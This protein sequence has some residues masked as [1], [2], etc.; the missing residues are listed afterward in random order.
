MRERIEALSP[1][2]NLGHRGA[3]TSRAANPFPENSRS[4][5]RAAIDQGA[6]GVELDVEL[7]SDGALVAMHDDT[8]DRT[9]TCGGCVSTKTL[10]EIRACRLRRG[11]GRPTDER[12]PTLAESFAAI[13]DDAVVNVELKVFGPECRTETTGP[14]ALARAAVERVRELGVGHRTMFSSFDPAA[15]AAVREES[16][17]YAA[18][19]LDRA[20]SV[21]GAWPAAIELAHASDL[22]AIHP[23]FAIPAAGVR[24]ARAA[25]L[26]VNVWTINRRKHMKRA[27]D[28][29][30]TAIITDEPA[31]LVGV[32]EGRP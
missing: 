17:F 26:H 32:L 15:V 9:T 13:P 22:D 12:P 27:L 14:R 7:T 20:A 25:G 31:T 11:D 10:A 29:G 5:F 2:A 19:L 30:V 21:A 8:L 18:L 4:S 6:D 23:S 24:A 28:H 16:D 3:G 1:S